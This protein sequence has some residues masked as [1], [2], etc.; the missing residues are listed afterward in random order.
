MSR[1]SDDK[2][3]KVSGGI[4]FNDNNVSGADPSKPWEII[5]DKGRNIAPG[6][7]ENM[8]QADHTAA[9]VPQNVK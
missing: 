2:L 4:A 5:D 3:D 8:Q 6:G 9:G 7:F 1:L